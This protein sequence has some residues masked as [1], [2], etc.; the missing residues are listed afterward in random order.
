MLNSKESFAKF[1]ETYI[2]RFEN[3]MVELFE[4]ENV[5]ERKLMS[6][7]KQLRHPQLVLPS[8][9]SS[10]VNVLIEVFEKNDDVYE[11]TFSLRTYQEYMHHFIKDGVVKLSK[12][13]NVSPNSDYFD[14]TNY[15]NF[16]VS[17]NFVFESYRIQLVKAFLTSILNEKRRNVIRRVVNDRIK[18]NDA[19]SLTL[20][21]LMNIELEKLRSE[22]NVS[23]SVKKDNYFGRSNTIDSVLIFEKGAE[24][25]FIEKLSAACPFEEDLKLLDSCTRLG[26]LDGQIRLKGISSGQLG[27]LFFALVNNSIVINEPREIADFIVNRFVFYIKSKN[28]FK[29]ANEKALL[30]SITGKEDTSESDL[31]SI[32]DFI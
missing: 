1:I 3:S 4:D 8:Y 20:Q 7:I 23:S 24:K 25:D 30:S 11:A 10:A 26:R 31:I 28:T 22:N 21:G 19:T 17:D 15:Q 9:K 2:E 32:S 5:S 18:M 6:Y 16:I 13:S 29:E 14:K 27:C 12:N